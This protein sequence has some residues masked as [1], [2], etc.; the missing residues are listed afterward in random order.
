MKVSPSSLHGHTSSILSVALDHTASNTSCVAAGAEAGTCPVRIWDTRIDGKRCQLA[1]H[2][3]STATS[4]TTTGPRFLN[5]VT[6]VAFAPGHLLFCSWEQSIAAFDLRRPDQKVIQSFDDH[7]WLLEDFAADEVNQ[8][9]VSAVQASGKWKIACCEDGGDVHVFQAGGST[10]GMEIEQTTLSGV[11][12]N[13]CTGVR[14]QDGSSRILV[15][16]AMDATI[17]MWDV[18]KSKPITGGHITCGAAA[19]GTSSSGKSQLVNPP[20]VNSL[21]CSPTLCAVGLGDGTVGLYDTR[22]QQSRGQ[23]CGHDS[24]TCCVTFVREEQVES[25][26]ATGGLLERGWNTWARKRE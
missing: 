11:H 24:A 17:C 20:Y 1:I 21:D 8:I 3:H 2:K 18:L 7:V 4:A 9:A 6:S 23:L 15:S 14:W 12:A 13:M 5:G 16:G 10:A 22:T 26:E 19:N 25:D